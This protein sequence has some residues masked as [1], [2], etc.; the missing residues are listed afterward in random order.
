MKLF[1]VKHYIIKGGKSLRNKKLFLLLVSVVLA[2]TL[3]VGC[4]ASMVRIDGVDGPD[5]QSKTNDTVND[6]DELLNAQQWVDMLETVDLEGYQFVVATT[7]ENVILTD[8]EASSVVDEAKL[9]RNEIVEKKFNIEIVEKLYEAEE[10]LPAQSTAALVNTAIADI[11]TSPA[12]QMA[13]LASNGLLLNLYSVPYLNLNAKYVTEAM[14]VQYTAE[15]TA[16]M[17]FDDVISYQTNLWAAFYNVSL[18]NELGLEDPYSYVKNGTWTWDVMLE[19]AKSVLPSEESD[20]SAEELAENDESGDGAEENVRYYGL[21]SYYNGEE[22]LDLAYAMLGSMGQKY[23][24][25]TYR[26][27]MELSLDVSVANKAV[28]NFLDIIGSEM[29]YK[30]DGMSAITEFSEGRLLFYVYE[31]SLAAALANSKTEWSVAPLPKYSAEQEGYNSWLDTSAIA[32]GVFNTNTNT[33]RVGRIL[34]CLC[35]ASYEH[36]REAT[37]VA[38]INYYLRN[39]QSAVALTKYVFNNPFLDVTYLYGLGIEDL[40]SIT[41]EK[42]NKTVLDGDD[43]EKELYDEENKALAEE[44]AAGMFK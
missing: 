36:I 14:K 20:E 29:H 26:N 27:K 40:R 34:N 38:Y 8:E 5:E 28:E 31:T 30:G 10:I 7:R 41:F 21:A 43:L 1:H 33:S 2:L 17:M 39:N 13:V 35:A 42:F 6:V 18:V 19:M 32:I 15:N 3:L 9:L 37:D 23:F 44:F 4:S 24:G 12:E 16:F 11:V 22:D 25:D